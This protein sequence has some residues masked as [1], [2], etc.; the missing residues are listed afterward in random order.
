MAGDEPTGPV[1][2]IPR[3]PLRA[4]LDAS[5]L[6][7]G[8]LRDVLLTT[9]HTGR[10]FA[11]RWSDEILRELTDNL[12]EEGR[13]VAARAERLRA[14]MHGAFPFALVPSGGRLV[15][16]LTNHPKDRHVLETALVAQAEVIV[17]GNL[18]HFQPAD[19]APVGQVAQAPD[20]FLADLY[21]ERPEVLAD[22]LRALVRRYRRPTL[23]LA[24]LLP[25]L[26][27]S[28]PQTMAPASRDS[29]RR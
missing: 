3:R 8:S 25:I 23:Q 27:A 7:P 14:A 24:E 17:T 12:V 16:C 18:R 1:A 2:P 20:E 26:S 13:M 28:L 19:L 4:V 10:L 21:R 15:A 29:G 22:V 11:P 9:T 5:V 6:F